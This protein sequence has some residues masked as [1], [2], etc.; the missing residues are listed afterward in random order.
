[1]RKPACPA[2]NLLDRSTT[3]GTLTAC[4]TADDLPNW[5]ACSLDEPRDDC[6]GIRCSF[7]C[8]RTAIG[9]VDP[10]FIETVEHTDARIGILRTLRAKQPVPAF[11]GD[12]FGTDRMVDSFGEGR[13]QIVG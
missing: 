10:A 12:G 4:R 2:G 9:E 7:D 13:C 1:M 3:D 6:L 5:C 11:A 8:M